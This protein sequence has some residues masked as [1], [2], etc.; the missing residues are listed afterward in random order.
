M[1]RVAFRRVGREI[2]KNIFERIGNRFSPKYRKTLPRNTIPALHSHHSTEIPQKITVVRTLVLLFDN[3]SG[4]SSIAKKVDTDISNVSVMSPKSGCSQCSPFD[5]KC[6][7][8]SSIFIW[9]EWS[10]F[11]KHVENPAE[12]RYKML[13]S[14]VCRGS[15]SRSSFRL[16][17]LTMI[18]VSMGKSLA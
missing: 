3:K 6:D 5:R 15:S 9:I 2:N 17:S 16:S 7:T 4:M 10:T 12:V 13:M 11:H 18:L 1:K 14:F 8:A